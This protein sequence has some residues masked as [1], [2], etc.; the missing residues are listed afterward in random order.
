[1]YTSHVHICTHRTKF[2][3]Q[4]KSVRNEL[5]FEKGHVFHVVD[6]LP[7]GH[8]GMWRVEKVGSKGEIGEMGLV[9]LSLR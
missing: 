5:T 9:P 7:L 2:P 3:Y 1:M 6:T 8:A 4:K